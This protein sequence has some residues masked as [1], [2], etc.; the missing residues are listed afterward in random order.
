MRPFHPF[1]P[2]VE[3]L[4][5]EILYFIVVVSLCLIIYRRTKELYTLSKHQGIYHFR[6]IFL[7]FAIAYAFRLA[8]GVLLLSRELLDFDAPRALIGG[9]LF[10]TGY[11]ST[12]AILSVVMTFL[13]RFHTI[14]ARTTSLLLHGL[15]IASSIVVFVT[16]SGKMLILVQA[17]V[18]ALVLLTSL[19][20]SRKKQKNTFLSYNRVTFLLLFVFW[21]LNTW[22]I[23]KKFAPI[24]IKIP[25]YILSIAVFLYLFVRVH[26]RIA[27]HG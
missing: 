6:N 5:I 9:G 20:A 4:G 25:L 3:I 13:T 19:I 16:R 23:T 1:S 15:A 14:S 10:F 26:K 21:L 7:Y 17:I 24:E 22:L 8:S 2:P 11:F 18:F 12:L 27:H